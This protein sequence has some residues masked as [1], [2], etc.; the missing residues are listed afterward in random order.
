M[1]YCVVGFGIR[2]MAGLFV[3]NVI[4]GKPMQELNLG[5]IKLPINSATKS[6]AIL[7]V[8]GSGKTGAAGVIAEEFVK[9]GIPFVIFDP[10]DVHWGLRLTA[11]GKGKGLPVVVF[12][13]EHADLPLEKEMGRQI[14]QAVIK[15]NVSCVISTFGM[16]KKSQRF[17]ITEFAEELLNKNNTPRH[18]FI[19]EAHEFVPQRVFGELGRAFNAVS[20]LV[21]MGRNRGLGVTLLNQRAA[22]INKDVLTQCENILVF[23]TPSPQDK[24]ALKKWV[25]DN[26]TDVQFDRFVDS[27]PKLPTREGWFWSPHFLQKFEKVKIRLRETFH[28]DREK[29]GEHFQM[30]QLD[31]GDLQ[32]F[33]NRFRSAI[34]PKGKTETV[35]QAMIPQ[36]SVQIQP[37]GFQ[38]TALKNEYESQLIQKDMEIRRLM[39]IIQSAQK[40]LSIN[41]NSSTPISMP[42]TSGLQLWLNKFSGGTKR[43]LEFM[44]E[45]PGRKVDRGQISIGTQLSYTSGS[46]SE[47]LGRLKRAKVI[48]Q[49]GKLFYLN[50]E[51]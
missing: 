18:I 50:P 15:E 21:V 9:V 10:I 8:R 2:K 3:K 16:S 14:A 30:P 12:G 29:L 39:G 47:Y 23:R 34:V 42:S 7:G 19:E 43:I 5:S 51:L 48:L 11:D 24:A 32:G 41:L 27:L 1:P 37:E 6:F 13:L 25:E 40:V 33:I 49:D 45:V 22:T 20:N 26:A 17:L 38:L 36:P 46:L 44:A 28:P 35:K 4:M 31:Q